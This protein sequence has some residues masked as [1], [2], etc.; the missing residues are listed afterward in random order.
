MRGFFKS[1]KIFWQF[2][3]SFWEI[4]VQRQ[5]YIGFNFLILY[6]TFA[7]LNVPTWTKTIVADLWHFGTYP[8][9]DPDLRIST[10]DKRIRNTGT[11]TSFFK[12]KKSQRSHRTAEI[13]VFLI[14]FAWWWK[15]PEP[16]P[17]LWLT[18]PDGPK[19]YG[20]YGSGTLAKTICRDSPLAMDSD[21]RK[22]K[23]Q[24]RTCSSDRNCCPWLQPKHYGG[25]V[26]ADAWDEI[27]A[28]ASE[29]KQK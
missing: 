18:D 9:A 1:N 10:C 22:T 4:F 29:T 27:T 16:D 3:L 6:R 17:Y 20:S 26:A 24:Y 2:S 5:L 19:T 15:D 7:L 21:H 8:D 13:K 23:A 14:I 25:G 28:A 12:D 11:F